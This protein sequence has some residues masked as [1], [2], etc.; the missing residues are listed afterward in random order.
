MRE[1][2]S[3]YIL[4]PEIT[5][6]KAKEFALKMKELILRE[7]GK[8]I[9]VD[10]L[11]RRKL[12]WERKKYQRGVY[13]QHRYLGNPGLVTEYERMLAIEE[14]VILRQSVLLNKNVNIEAFEE[15]PDQLEIP[16]VKERK[17]IQ[18]SNP[19]SNSKSFDEGSAEQNIESNFDEN[20]EHQING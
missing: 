12:A 14:N 8:N 7:G 9:K 20:Q 5:D 18:R 11:G 15:Q 6:F 10:C 13:I 17:E 4:N 1:Y 16:V 3:I 2:E 19:E